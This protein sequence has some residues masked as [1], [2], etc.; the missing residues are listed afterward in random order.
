MCNIIDGWMDKQTGYLEWF[1]SEMCIII[2][3]WI[4]RQYDCSNHL[5]H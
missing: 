4:N 3:G 5:G 1:E 2:D